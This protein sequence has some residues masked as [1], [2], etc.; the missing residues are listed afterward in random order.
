MRVGLD[1]ADHEF[2]V[3]G[4]QPFSSVLAELGVKLGRAREVG[5]QHR[6]RH[7]PHAVGHGRLLP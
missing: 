4:P 1:G 7:H 3:L 6:R 5:E 2:V